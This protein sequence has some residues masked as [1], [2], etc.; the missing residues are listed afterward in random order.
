MHSKTEK[1]FFRIAMFIIALVVALVLMFG[2][3]SCGP[4]PT[5]NVPSASPGQAESEEVKTAV[6]TAIGST[7][8]NMQNGRWVTLPGYAAE[9]V[10]VLLFVDENGI[11]LCFL[12]FADPYDA[13]GL[14]CTVRK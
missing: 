9:D 12:A 5:P 13:I 6:F 8:K 7:A 11:P 1:R 4:T 14:S 3:V 10:T 2:P